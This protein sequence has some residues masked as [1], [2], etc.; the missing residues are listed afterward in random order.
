MMIDEEQTGVGYPVHPFGLS[1][2]PVLPIYAITSAQ[3]AVIQKLFHPV[4][5]L[6]KPA[7]ATMRRRLV[8]DRKLT[9][10]QLHQVYPS[11]NLRDKSVSA[12][13]PQDLSQMVIGATPVCCSDDGPFEALG[14]PTVTF[15]GNFQF[16]AANHPDWAYPFDQPSD[17]PAALACDTGGSPKP[18]AAL[19]ANLSIDV[20]MSYQLVNQ[21]AA[22]SGPLHTFAVITSRVVAGHQA[23]FSAAGPGPITW[24]FGD[25]SRAKGATVHHTYRHAGKY[26]VSVH[27]PSAAGSGD[28]SVKRSVKLP[29]DWSNV[30]KAPAVRPFAPKELKGISGCP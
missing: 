18:S 24:S 29:H 11:L 21:Y 27:S 5:P 15:S 23:E 7:L 9:F 26:M 12:F 6:D 19:E 28:V 8:A 16:Y 3:G 2:E 10:S 20:E 22:P 13:T 25:G 4:K 17:T 1:T 14:L 30:P